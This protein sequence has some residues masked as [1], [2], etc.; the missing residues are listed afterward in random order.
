MTAALSWT[1]FPG[2]LLV[3]PLLRTSAHLDSHNLTATSDPANTDLLDDM[4]DYTYT[5]E[6]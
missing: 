6:D 1:N 5:T 2:N 3:N 4:R